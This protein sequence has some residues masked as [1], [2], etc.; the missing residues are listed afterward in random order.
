M[1]DWVVHHVTMSPAVDLSTMRHAVALW[2]VGQGSAA[3]IVRA[4]CDLLVAGLDGPELC[5]LAA[6]SFR[7]AD[8]EVPR[9]L[10]AALQEV[11]LEHHQKGSVAAD[12]A[13]LRAMASRV[14]SGV[15][16]PRSLASWAHSTFGHDTLESAE[17][18]AELD[19]A[20]DMLE[21]PPDRTFEQLDIEIAAE[22]RRI[23]MS[24]GRR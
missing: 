4:A 15:L 13:A 17:R 5:I 20:Y 22:A 2:H 14:L 16:A 7:H 9:L 24:E 21:Y 3:D 12:E 19:D 18:L 23:V 8:E 1:P 10:E 11:G 6:V